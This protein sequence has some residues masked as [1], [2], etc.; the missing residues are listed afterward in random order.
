MD[1]LLGAVAISRRGAAE[2][3]TV[4]AVAA[5]EVAEAAQCSWFSSQLLRAV[6]LLL[7]PM[8][9][10]G[11][12]A[13]GNAAAGG[14][15]ADGWKGSAKAKSAGSLNAPDKHTCPTTD[16]PHTSR[17]LSPPRVVAVAGDA[18]LRFVDEDDDDKKDC[19]GSVETLRALRVV[20]RRTRRV[21]APFELLQFLLPPLACVLLT[22]LWLPSE[23]PT[24]AEAA[25]PGAVEA[26]AEGPTDSTV[27]TRGCTVDRLNIAR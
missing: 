12:D 19:P 27:P 1:E 21:V 11:V 2:S 15:G 25:V 20:T 24:D 14:T 7:S 3:A 18:G 4:E 23:E 17:R 26:S 8:L 16:T 9:C 5:E 13:A 6:Q 22:R 10:K